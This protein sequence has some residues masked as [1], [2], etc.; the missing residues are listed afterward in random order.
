[1][2][3][4]FQRTCYYVIDNYHLTKLKKPRWIKFT[5]INLYGVP[6]P[7]GLVHWICVLMAESSEC[8]FESRLQ[9]VVL[10][11]LSKT[12]YHNCLA[13]CAEMAAI[14]LYTPQ[15]LPDDQW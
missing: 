3:T 10:M 1:M 7:S 4:K 11:S 8:G 14:E 9:P 2:R 13:L 6:W 12:L 5:N 15:G